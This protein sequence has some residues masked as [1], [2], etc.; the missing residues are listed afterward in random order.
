MYQKK[1]NFF[2]AWA[3]IC[4]LNIAIAQRNYILGEIIFESSN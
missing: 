3:L 1:D 4:Q 2:F